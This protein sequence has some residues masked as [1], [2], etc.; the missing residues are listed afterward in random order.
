MVCSD[1]QL[2]VLEDTEMH[3]GLSWVTCEMMPMHLPFVLGSTAPSPPYFPS[4]EIFGVGE[5][6]VCKP[7]IGPMV[8][9]SSLTKVCK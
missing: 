8:N 6:C 9:C 7:G 2:Q 5:A 1:K 3:A 4:M